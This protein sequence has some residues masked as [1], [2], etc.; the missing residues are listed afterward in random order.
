[1]GNVYIFNT[2]L[3]ELTLTINGQATSS[4]L[5]AMTFTAENGYKFGTLTVARTE[6]AKPRKAVFGDENTLAVTRKTG[7][8]NYKVD[9]NPDE[10]PVEQDM[11]MVIF[12][13]GMVLSYGGVVL[14][15]NFGTLAASEATALALSAAGS[16]KSGAQKGGK[17]GTAK[18]R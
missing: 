16:A 3:Q 12:Y 8:D 10:H 13:K 4:K 11:Q 14:Q 2:T 1:M 7:T 6:D 17:K 5:A 15:N 18:K 9:I